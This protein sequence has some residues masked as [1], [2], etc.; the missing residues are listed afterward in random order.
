MGRDRCIQRRVGRQTHCLR[1]KDLS[2][3]DGGVRFRTGIRI[4]PPNAKPSCCTRER[5]ATGSRSP[6]PYGTGRA[7]ACGLRS[8]M[9]E[10]SMQQILAPLQYPDAGE[11]KM[12]EAVVADT[13]SAALAIWQPHGQ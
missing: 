7:N 1:A 2:P 4:H 13:I 11:F 5:E 3:G 12:L 8:A 9:K 6:A 10:A